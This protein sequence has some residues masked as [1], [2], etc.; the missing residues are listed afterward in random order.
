VT[1]QRGKHG[2]K[3]RRG[4]FIATNSVGVDWCV[5]EAQ[6]ARS[7]GFA[8]TASAAT[9]KPVESPPR[10][11]VWP[12]L[13]DRIAET[14]PTPPAAQIGTVKQ[15]P[16]CRCT[17]RQERAKLCHASAP[18][19][20]FGAVN[21]RHAI[22]LRRY[23]GFRAKS[24]CFSRDSNPGGFGFFSNWLPSGRT[25]HAFRSYEI[26]GQKICEAVSGSGAV[27]EGPGA[28]SSVF[29]RS[30]QCTAGLTRT[31][32]SSLVALKE[33]HSQYQTCTSPDNMDW[34]ACRRSSSRSR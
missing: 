2:D 8:G 16:V 10:H 19:G 6:W 32:N 18:S 1:G 22:T 30:P 25:S 9:I 5:V 12:L 34:F 17:E 33:A 31:R 4:R 20:I 13:S 28:D 7:L 23:G 27:S 24:G 11:D 21:G 29:G 26:R 3:Q 15:A 14:R